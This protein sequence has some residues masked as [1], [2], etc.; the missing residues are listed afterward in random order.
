M[1][2]EAPVTTA[3]ASGLG[4]GTGMGRTISWATMSDPRPPAQTAGRSQVLAWALWDCGA[5][6]VS[7][8]V[9][10]FV[11]SVYLTGTVGEDLPGDTSPA[12]WLGWA[13]ALAGLAV[14][15]LAP[16]TGI[17]VDAPWRRRRVLAVLTGLVVLLTSAM[18]LIRDDYR[19]LWPGL[20]AARVRGGLQ[21]LA[22]VPYN[23]M[24]RQLSTPETSGR[25]SGF[26]WGK[27]YF[28]SVVLLLDRLLG[29]ISGDGDNRGLLGIPT[30][31]GQNVRAAMLSTAAWFALFAL[32]RAHR[33]PPPDA[34]IED[35]R[36]GR[37]SACSAPTASCGRK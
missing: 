30:A 27:G 28:G 35:R 13:L 17:W 37:R 23:A 22:T 25:I 19:Y 34:G 4:A 29:F 24:L 36:H 26:G 14:A 18:S 31:D 32:P 33:V 6:G 1:F 16:V 9:V 20:G 12:S 15:L 10:T 2:C 3:R 21:R 8:I 7:A 5:T 11:F